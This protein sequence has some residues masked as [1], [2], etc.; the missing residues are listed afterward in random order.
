MQILKS[1]TAA[2]GCGSD[3]GN[4]SRQTIVVYTLGSALPSLHK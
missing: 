4:I 3:I 1:V 2:E